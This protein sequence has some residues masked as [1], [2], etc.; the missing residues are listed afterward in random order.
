M[1]KWYNFGIDFPF[2]ILKK[3]AAKNAL[4]VQNIC[5]DF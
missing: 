4:I 1:Y 2:G 3:T 5:N